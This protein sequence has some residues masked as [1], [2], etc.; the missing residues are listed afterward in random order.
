MSLIVTF[1]L[2]KDLCDSVAPA[3]KGDALRAN[4]KE[5]LENG[6]QQQVPVTEY[7]VPSDIPTERFNLSLAEKYATPVRA[8]AEK[9]GITPRQVCQGVIYG[10]AFRGQAME[11]SVVTALQQSLDALKLGRRTE[12]LRFFDYLASSLKSPGIGLCEAGTGTGKTLAML[13]ATKQQ[14]DGSPESRLVI[15]CPTLMTMEQFALQYRNMVEAGI[16]MPPLRILVGRR[17]FVS[18]AEVL[19]IAE[20]G[21]VDPEVD[22]DAVL[23]WVHGGGKSH[24]EHWID[25]P[26]L[27]WSLA[28]VAPGF[29]IA[30]AIL[31][32]AS[33]EEDPGL[34]AYKAQFHVVDDDP[35]PEIILCTHSMIAV[36][37]RRRMIQVGRDGDY[38]QMSEEISR[39]FADIKDKGA[40]DRKE[41]SSKIVKAR[42]ESLRYGAELSR[43]SGS[44][45]PYHY[46]LVD[47]AHLLESAFSNALS[48]YVSLHSFY[49]RLDDYRKGGGKSRISLRSCA[50]VL[51]QI[52]RL[53][54]LSYSKS[55]DSFSLNEYSEAGQAASEALREICHAAGVLNSIRNSDNDPT[56]VSLKRDLKLICIAGERLTYSRAYLQMSPIRAFPQLFV[57]APSVDHALSFLWAGCRSGACVSATLYLPRGD[58]FSSAFQAGLLSIPKERQIEFPPVTPEWTYTTV[59]QAYLPESTQTPGGKLWLRPPSRKDALKN[60]QQ[61]EADTE[62]LSELAKAVTEIHSTAAG[63]VLVLMTSYAHIKKLAEMLPQDIRR[64]FVVAGPDMTLTAQRKRFLTLSHQGHKPVWIATGSAWTGLDVGGHAPWATLFGKELPAAEDNV[65]TDLVIPRIPF[66]TNKSLTH[67]SRMERNRLVPWDMLD[68]IFRMKQG[69]GRLVR[70]GGLPANRRIFI[71]DGRIND[72]S[73]GGY[74]SRIR[75]LVSGYHQGIF[76]YRESGN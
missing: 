46:I 71:L 2:P 12:Q 50:H 73:F 22:I 61:N 11:S 49:R 44:I 31:S 57:G 53:A 37:I 66:G 48:N 10:L 47:E 62:W 33:E 74:L 20:S 15:T 9:M 38:R 19:R 6:I 54:A 27:A 41:I 8:M 69:M 7:D 17:E 64:A 59:S 34:L 40:D 29:P 51:A 67:I 72:P 16:T 45:P 28:H 3:K 24:D 60:E 21:K 18:P 43:D 5:L 76:K 75:A 30:A 55:I 35:M 36:D 25:R 65:L 52:Q 58:G 68:A 32:E 42:A 63:G 4:I 39:M 14:L 23:A 56:L 13:T 26:W 1:R 70:R